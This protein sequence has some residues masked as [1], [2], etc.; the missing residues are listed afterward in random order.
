LK[1]PS[2]RW[3]RCQIVIDDVEQDRFHC[4]NLLGVGQHYDPE[5]FFRDQLHGVTKPDKPPLWPISFLA[6]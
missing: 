4:A 5:I 2:N 1:A 6:L 3:S